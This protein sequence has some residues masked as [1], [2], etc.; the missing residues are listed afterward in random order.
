MKKTTW[1]ECEGFFA[2]VKKQVEE[3]GIAIVKLDDAG[4]FNSEEKGGALL[5]LEFCIR[6][7]TDIEK[8]KKNKSISGDDINGCLSNATHAMNFLAA[9]AVPNVHN[10]IL[11]LKRV[12]EQKSISAE[13]HAVVTEKARALIKRRPGLSN[14]SIADILLAENYTYRKRDENGEEIRKTYS[15]RTLRDILRKMK[16]K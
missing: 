3:A 15:K 9:Y 14:S 10:K 13:D 16:K 2:L 1:K 5:A 12:R 11:C 8:F 4:F 6:V 7:R